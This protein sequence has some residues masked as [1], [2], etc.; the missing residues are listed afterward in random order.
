M[1]E[2]KDIRADVPGMLPL[3]ADYGH[4]VIFGVRSI[5]L[6]FLLHQLC[7]RMRNPSLSTQ[8]AQNPW[9]RKASFNLEGEGRGENRA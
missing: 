5:T 4:D 3:Q 8:H 1:L 2:P 6:I 9:L 7:H